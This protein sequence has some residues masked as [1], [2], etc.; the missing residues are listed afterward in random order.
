MACSYASVSNA[1]KVLMHP[2]KRRNRHYP[3]ASRR[4][5]CR[6]DDAYGFN[7]FRVQLDSKTG[8]V[9]LTLTAR[10][11]TSTGAKM[12]VLA[13]CQNMLRG[14]RVDNATGTADVYYLWR[15]FEVESRREQQTSQFRLPSI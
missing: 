8:R 5:W 9:H 3:T 1:L 15:C 12:P 6:N 2:P 11:G 10:Q 14:P 4:P 7:S 13:A